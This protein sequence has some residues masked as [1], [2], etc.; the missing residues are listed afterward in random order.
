LK[1]QLS[2]KEEEMKL[3]KLLFAVAALLGF[4]ASGFAQNMEANKPKGILGYLDPK[5]GIFRSLTREVRSAA[6]PAAT[7]TTGTFVFNVTITVSSTAPK[8]PIECE[9]F[10]GVD[11]AAGDFTN[12]V[13]TVATVSGTTAKCT[14]S[15]PYEWD[16]DTP[17]TD[18]V[19]LDLTVFTDSSSTK[20]SYEESMSVPVYT[21]KVPANGA[22]T[23]ETITTTI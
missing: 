18:K 16:L 21:G 9:V 19:A 22:T 7:P 3:S 20:G 2:T 13:T 4:V 8:G 12:E 5:T 1:P 6:D 10:G 17:S 15:I 11:D 14:V 23:T